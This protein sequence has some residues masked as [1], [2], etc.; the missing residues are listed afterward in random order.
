MIIG[1]KRITSSVPVLISNSA[2]AQDRVSDKRLFQEP[3][4][5]SSDLLSEAYG[6]AEQR[7]QLSGLREVVDRIQSKIRERHAQVKS[8]LLLKKPEQDSK[9]ET[10]YQPLAHKK[11]PKKL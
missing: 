8:E 5:Q 4:M 3:L 10:P 7:K 6:D 1:G 2:Q 9:E 11:K